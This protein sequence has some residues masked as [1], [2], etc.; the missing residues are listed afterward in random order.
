MEI[1]FDENIA[2]QLADAMDAL[3]KHRGKIRVYSTTEVFSAGDQDEELI[4]KIGQR[5]GI[6]FT[7]DLRGCLNL[8]L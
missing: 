1:F 4:P 6:L 5:G 2:P 3:E 8:I 7:H